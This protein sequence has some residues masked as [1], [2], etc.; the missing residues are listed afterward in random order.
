MSELIKKKS[1]LFAIYE[2]Y[3]KIAI[4]FCDLQEY[5]A[6]LGLT[7]AVASLMYNLNFI[8]ILFNKLFLIS[9][10]F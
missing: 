7:S 8:Y 1:E 3:K 9:P 10:L 6:A 2:K 4:R 5:E